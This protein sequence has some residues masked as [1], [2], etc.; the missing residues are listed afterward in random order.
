MMFEKPLRCLMAALT[1]SLLVLGATPAAFAHDDHEDQA[2][3]F[4]LGAIDKQRDPVNV[5]PS[6]SVQLTETERNAGVVNLDEIMPALSQINQRYN[7]FT[8]PQFNYFVKNFHYPYR[9]RFQVGKQA[10]PSHIVLHWTAN[11]RPDIPLY[12]FSAFLRSRRNGRIVERANRH[13]NVSNYYL[14]GNIGNSAG[15]QS[16]QLVKLTR[17]DLRSWGDIP[18]VTAYPTSEQWDDNKY[19]GRGAIGIEIESPNFSVFYGNASQRE[20]LHNFLVLVLS[21]RGVLNEFAALRKSPHWEDMTKLHQYLL[22]NLSK[23]DVDHRGGI[24]QNYQHLD[25]MLTYFNGIN[26]AGVYLEARKMY[27]YISG[28][29]IVAREYNERMQ[30]ARRYR[31]A[32]Y[33]KID[34]TEAHVFVLAMDL[35]KSDMQYRGTDSDYFNPYAMA[36][37]RDRLV[38]SSTAQPSATPA[39]VRPEPTYRRLP[40]GKSVQ[41][42]ASPE[43][44]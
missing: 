25:K 15:G 30:K 13:K 31:D 14:T 42:E 1:G 26:K 40:N 28:H 37:S 2:E 8:A 24:A 36:S 22:S 27:K 12:T 20:K 5:I 16:A 4:Q 17:G 23:I 9:D 6:R 43:T 44:N 38:L 18:R 35:L 29:G 11:S 34:F 33:D 7:I 39:K 10:P 32:N 19:D 3:A 41:V 21:E